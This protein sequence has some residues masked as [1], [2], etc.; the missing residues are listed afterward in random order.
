M[1][2]DFTP[3]EVVYDLDEEIKKKVYALYD[4]Y[5][6][7]KTE[8]SLFEVLNY[9]YETTDTI[10]RRE[11]FD[12][13]LIDGRTVIDYFLDLDEDLSQEN[14]EFIASQEDYLIKGLLKGKFSIADKIH[15]DVLFK[16]INGKPLLE[17]LINLENFRPYILTCIKT[18]KEIIDILKRT[19]NVRYLEY[20]GEDILFSLFDENQTVMEYLIENDMYSPHLLDTIKEHPELYDYLVKYRKEFY[21]PCLSSE[22]LMQEKDGR[23]L[24]DALLDSGRHIYGVKIINEEMVKIF[25]KYGLEHDLS[26][27]PY[28]LAFME[29]EGTDKKLFEHLTEKGVLC[30]EVV[31]GAVDKKE[32]M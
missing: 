7:S 31:A 30:Y 20:V 16:D 17:Y 27:V 19:N 23:I 5:L 13:K 14:S 24:L 29:V 21:V 12:L 15:E 32:H 11:Y 6:K 25:L 18:R 2:F 22:I 8:A 28:E 26:E 3:V 9:I 4:K 10:N 1:K